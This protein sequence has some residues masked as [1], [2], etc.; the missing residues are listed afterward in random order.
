M[1]NQDVT[2]TAVTPSQN[3]AGLGES[4]TFTATV[5]TLSPGV[6]PATGTVT[7]L[8]GATSLGSVAL[9]GG[10]ATLTLNTLSVGAHSITARYAGASNF[11]GSNSTALT[12]TVISDVTTTTITPANTTANFGQVVNL[13]ATVTAAV[14]T[15]T[16][17]VTFMDGATPI[18]SGSLNGSGQFTLSIS[19]L[20]FGTHTISVSYSPNA[21]F[22]PSNSTSSATVTVTK[23]GSTTSVSS[24][25]N[26]SPL[27]STVIFTATVIPAGTG[28]GTPTGTA[29]LHGW[30]DRPGDRDSQ[31]RFGDLL[32]EHPGSGGPQ[33]H[34]PFTMAT[35]TSRRV[36]LSC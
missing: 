9:S 15:P 36:P 3:P 20:A 21:A 27:N 13:T 5:T 4:I 25:S 16:G 11:I 17:T 35:A 28:T 29:D 14:G 22:N 10:V 19:T 12:E 30:H 8:D 6:G 31:R 33:H 26:P 2:T 32:D 1:V 23:T 18:G 24:S 34:P 7:F